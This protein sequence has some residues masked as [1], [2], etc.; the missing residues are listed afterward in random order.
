MLFIRERERES[1][2]SG[3]FQRWQKLPPL[4]WESWKTSGSTSHLESEPRSSS[5]SGASTSFEPPV[6]LE[7]NCRARKALGHT[8]D[9]FDLLF[10]FLQDW[11]YSD[12][13]HNNCTRTALI[14]LWSTELSHYSNLL[15]GF[16]GISLVRLVIS[17]VFSLV[18][19]VISSLKVVASSKA[20]PRLDSLKATCNRAL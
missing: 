5:T 19:L 15:V 8:W 4:T 9:A 7:S 2:I 13:V 17:L 16:L 1:D 10:P 6:E 3:N 11:D 14:L 20:F 12:A 18:R